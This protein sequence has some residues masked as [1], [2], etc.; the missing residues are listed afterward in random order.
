MVNATIKA[1][2]NAWHGWIM[3]WGANAPVKAR[4]KNGRSVL[5]QPGKEGA[6]YLIDAD[7]LGIQ[8][9]RMQITDLCGTTSDPCKA[10]WMGMIVTQP[11]L[12]YINGE[13]IV[14]I[15]TFVPDKS[16]PAGLTALKIVLEN[17]NPKLKKVLA[18]PRPLNQGIDSRLP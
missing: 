11:A 1:F 2:G 6:V 12:S 15:P 7:H 8:Y 4:L 14:I 18:I 9:D 5:V 13:P 17:G 10:S 16:H 3:T